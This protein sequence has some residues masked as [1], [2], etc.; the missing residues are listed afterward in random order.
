MK[1]PVVTFGVHIWVTQ[2][3]GA[4][5][6]EREGSSCELK[7]DYGRGA[8]N[9]SGGDDVLTARNRDLGHPVSP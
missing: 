4:I 1:R 2:A 7:R 5:Q 9:C 6:D 8:C 3:S